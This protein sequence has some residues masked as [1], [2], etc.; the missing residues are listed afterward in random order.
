M[1]G[2]GVIADISTAIYR[3]L[4]ARKQVVQFGSVGVIGGIV[5]NTLLVTLVEVGGIALIVSSILSKELSILLMFGINEKWT[6]SGMGTA[7]S[8]GLSG[9]LVKSNLVR[10]GGATVGIGTLYLLHTWFGVWYLLANVLGIGF[11]F[12]FN[13]MLESY[14]TWQTY[15]N[16]VQ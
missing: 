16:S 15:D 5:D 2:N 1:N 13:Y 8:P 3:Q 7:G 4:V 12:I 9:R 14:V 6:F 11:G 10:A